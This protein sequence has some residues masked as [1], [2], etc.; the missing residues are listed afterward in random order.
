[1]HLEVLGK[2]SFFSMALQVYALTPVCVH[3]LPRLLLPHPG[4]WKGRLP[5]VDGHSPAARVAIHIYQ[6]PSGGITGV[7]NA[8][9]YLAGGRGNRTHVRAM[10]GIEPTT[11]AEQELSLR[12]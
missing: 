11:K 2:S 4:P 9:S 5:W 7:A 8:P 3:P 12:C 10:V 1:M 6:P